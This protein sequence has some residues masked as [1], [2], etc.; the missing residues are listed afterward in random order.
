MSKVI[1]TFRIRFQRKDGKPISRRSKFA[2]A[3]EELRKR[4]VESGFEDV[5]KRETIEDVP[6]E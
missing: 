2:K 1:Y 4:L 6:C 3:C 5:S